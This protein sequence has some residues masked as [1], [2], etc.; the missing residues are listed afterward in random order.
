MV[1]IKKI[2]KIILPFMSVNS[3]K[4]NKKA[5]VKRMLYEEI[6]NKNLDFKK[7]LYIRNMSERSSIM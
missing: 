5:E 2:K 4:P 1:L 3:I 7:K 6:K